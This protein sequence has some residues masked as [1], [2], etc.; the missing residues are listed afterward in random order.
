MI[1]SNIVAIGVGLA[2]AA[3]PLFTFKLDLVMPE[4]LESLSCDGIPVNN[5]MLTYDLT[6]YTI[7]LAANCTILFRD[8]FED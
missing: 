2:M 4:G 5:S 8:G 6:N 1:T 7:Q 3:T